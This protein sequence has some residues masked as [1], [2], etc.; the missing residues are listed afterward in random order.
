MGY[1]FLDQKKFCNVIKSV[2]KVQKIEK[3]EDQVQNVD[4]LQSQSC[5]ITRIRFF[6]SIKINLQPL[7]KSFELKFN[8][9]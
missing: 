4:K 3:A 9:F 2:Q 1:F 8:P 5:K 6:L 7:V